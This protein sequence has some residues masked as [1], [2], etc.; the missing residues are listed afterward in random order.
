MFHVNENLTLRVSNFAIVCEPERKESSV[1][2]KKSKEVASLIPMA[3]AYLKNNFNVLLMGPHGTGKTASIMDF[4][5]KND[6]RVKYFSCATLDPYT[7]LVGVP[8]PKMDENGRDYLQMVRPRDVDNAEI[9]FFDEFNRADAKTTNAVFEI[10]QFRSINGEP[11]PNLSCC[12]AA[13][14][15]PEDGYNVEELDPALMDRFD[16][17]IEIKPRP[18]VAYMSDYIPEPLAQ[19][20]KSWWDDQD[21]KKRDFKDYVSPRRLLKLGQVYI[22]TDNAQ[23]VKYALPPGGK[24][25]VS[26]LITMMEIAMG[27]KEAAATGFGGAANPNFIY[28]TGGL[29]R[30]KDEL[31]EFLK[32]NPNELETH[33]N[34]AEAIKNGNVGPD[35]ITSQFAEILDALN[36]SMVESMFNS[37]SS[38]KKSQMR[39]SFQQIKKNDP[40][41]ANG[42]TNLEGIL[43]RDARA[44]EWT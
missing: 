30:A 5:Q 20:L 13:I 10:I 39:A 11:L 9:I 15:P 14:N 42:L 4:A 32:N 28:T 41:R 33:K 25:D 22:A 12:W 27:K 1:M 8:V 36:P 23:A 31:I 21:R 26:K 2:S 29:F 38:S 43:K 34:V 7:D 6:L 24:F 18:S 40:N 37:M 35:T 3:D 44:G 16:A 19:A 17:F